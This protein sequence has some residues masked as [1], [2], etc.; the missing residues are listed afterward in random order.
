MFSRSSNK[1]L[2]LST[3]ST[4]LV[5]EIRAKSHLCREYAFILIING[6]ELKGIAQPSSK[7][8]KQRQDVELRDSKWLN[9]E[10]TNSQDHQRTKLDELS[11][12][13]SQGLSKEKYTKTT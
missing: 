6:W 13:T 3:T 2:I 4:H 7:E 8:Q 10:F 1:L 11:L 5:E 9:S 12:F